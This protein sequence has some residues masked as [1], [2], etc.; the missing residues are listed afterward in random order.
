MQP[1]WLLPAMMLFRLLPRLLPQFTQPCHHIWP[2]LMAV[3]LQPTPLAVSPVAPPAGPAAA[4]PV[5]T[6]STAATAMS[7]NI[8]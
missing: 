4:G 6:T 3:S 1:S 7:K 2:W 8:Q 5:T